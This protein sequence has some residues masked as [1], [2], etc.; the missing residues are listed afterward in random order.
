MKAKVNKAE[1]VGSNPIR[2]PKTYGPV[3]KWYDA[4]IRISQGG[5]SGQ[6]DCQSWS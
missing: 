5:S 1:I 4:V 2:A 3:V 6:T